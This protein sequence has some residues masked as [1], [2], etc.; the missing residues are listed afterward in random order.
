M[1]THSFQWLS[2]RDETANLASATIGSKLRAATLYGEILAN[3]RPRN[4]NDN[5]RQNSE[6]FGCFN[7]LATNI[8]EM[9]T[10]PPFPNTESDLQLAPERH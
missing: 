6:S 1:Q 9:H 4:Y 5:R 2:A 10:F 7:I 8:S 3:D